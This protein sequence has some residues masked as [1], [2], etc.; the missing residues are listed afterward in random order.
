MLPGWLLS[1]ATKLLVFPE[2]SMTKPPYLFRACAMFCSQTGRPDASNEAGRRNRAPS[3]IPF[4][5][6]MLP[7][8]VYDGD[9]DV[10][11]F[12][13]SNSLRECGTIRASAW[14]MTAPACRSEGLSNPASS[15]ALEPLAPAPG[16][17]PLSVAS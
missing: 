12:C 4:V 5:P 11:R 7:S 8:D 13:P 9:R 3:G 16:I 14:S 6:V 15:S 17:Q 2:L 10:L 1:K